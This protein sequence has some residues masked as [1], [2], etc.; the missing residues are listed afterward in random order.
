MK[1][2]ELISG[3]I[4]FLSLFFWPAIWMWRLVLPRLWSNLADKGLDIV[5]WR[6]H[7]GGLGGYRGVCGYSC[8]LH[9]GNHR[10]RR[11]R[12]FRDGSA[13]KENWIIVSK[14]CSQKEYVQR[15]RCKWIL[16]WI[17]IVGFVNPICPRGPPHFCHKKVRQKYPYLIINFVIR[18]EGARQPLSFLQIL[19][20]SYQHGWLFGK[21]PKGLGVNFNLKIYVADFE[22]S[23][24]DL[25][26]RFPKKTCN[27]IFRK[28]QGRRQRPYVFFLKIHLFW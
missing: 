18:G 17:F 28:W 4:F 16:R 7:E 12:R 5:W 23:Y 8:N 6:G 9:I 25:F 24:R 10:L 3:R 2:L 15:E 26:G 14:K 11:Q 20:F 19:F 27:T 22:P 1:R 13:S 21:L